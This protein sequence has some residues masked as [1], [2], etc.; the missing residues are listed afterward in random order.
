MQDCI[1]CKIIAGKIPSKK[2][3][4]DQ[5][6]LV[7]EDIDPKA[8]IHYLLLP[9]KHIPTLMELS[10]NDQEVLMD[11]FLTA[12]DLA[13]EKEFEEQGFRLVANCKEGAGQSVFHLHFHLLAGRPLHWPPG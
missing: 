1:F 2:I 8:P 11:I 7:I 10:P 4:E 3:K 13:R 5:F 6:I 9:K 12:K